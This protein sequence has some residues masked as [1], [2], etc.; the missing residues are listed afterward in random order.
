[1]HIFSK[2]LQFL[3]E[4]AVV[5]FLLDISRHTVSRNTIFFLD[6]NLLAKKTFFGIL[7]IKVGD[8]GN[9]S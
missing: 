5:G 4:L 3:G 2:F 1:M 6:E 7:K 8:I 9:I